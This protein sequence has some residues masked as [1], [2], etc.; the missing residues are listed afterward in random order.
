MLSTSV[1]QPLYGKL[2]DIFGRK[3]CLQVAYILFGLGTL[4]CGLGMSMNQILTARV[5]QGAGGAG[6]VC[7]LAILL[8]DL[9]PM[10]EVATYRS[11]VN[12]AQTLGRSCGGAIGGVLAQSV[13]WRWYVS[14]LLMRRFR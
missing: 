8:T 11:Y 2:S 14:Q 7:V 13:G 9:V 12:I 1:V 4:G 6:M 3:R 5:I 10:H